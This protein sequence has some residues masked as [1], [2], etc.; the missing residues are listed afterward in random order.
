[1]GGWWE[2]KLNKSYFKDLIENWLVLYR[3]TNI[4][5]YFAKKYFFKNFF[6]FVFCK[7]FYITNQHKIFYGQF[8]NLDYA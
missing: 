2:D 4:C 7:I 1:M 8:I 5:V 3:L 6:V